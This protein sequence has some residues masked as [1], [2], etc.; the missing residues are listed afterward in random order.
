MNMFCT[1]KSYTS[2]LIVVNIKQ[3]SSQKKEKSSI[4][5]ERLCK[6]VSIKI[7]P[8]WASL[9]VNR[10]AV[11]KFVSGSKWSGRGQGIG[12]GADIYRL[13]SNVR[14]A[15]L[16]FANKMQ[17]IVVCLRLTLSP[18]LKPLTQSVDWTDDVTLSHFLDRSEQCAHPR[19]YHNHKLTRTNPLTPITTSK[20][21]AT[22]FHLTRA[23]LC[24]SQLMWP[25]FFY[26]DDNWSHLFRL[27]RFVHSSELTLA[28][29][30]FVEGL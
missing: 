18:I 1:Y 23:T 6:N 5:T 16:P 4:K 12:R 21:H 22:W 17:W 13:S 11:Q 30:F 7:G 2:W 27:L 24:S 15:C 25:I 3:K 19:S 28:F 29:I 9:W 20:T 26:S 14:V 10:G 8:N